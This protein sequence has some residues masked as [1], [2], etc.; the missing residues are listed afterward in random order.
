MFLDQAGEDNLLFIQTLA[1]NAE[2][3]EQ[4]RQRAEAG[5][6]SSLSCIETKQAFQIKPLEG[7][8]L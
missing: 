3:F 4:R 2:T 6:R 8:A 5:I 7:W 1:E